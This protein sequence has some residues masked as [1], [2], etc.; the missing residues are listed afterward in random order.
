MRARIVFGRVVHAGQ[1]NA[2]WASSIGHEILSGEMHT[3][4][5]V[6]HGGDEH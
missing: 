5:V 3:E 6:E 1:C 2:F 4:C